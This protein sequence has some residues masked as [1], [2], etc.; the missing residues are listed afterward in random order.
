MLP[1][2]LPSQPARDGSRLP[3][4]TRSSDPGR[5]GACCR[6][7]PRQVQGIVRAPSKNGSLALLTNSAGGETEGGPRR[8][9]IWRS[10]RGPSV[11]VVTR[12]ADGGYR[13]RPVDEDRHAVAH[14]S[15]GRPTT[16][17]NPRCSGTVPMPEWTPASIPPIG[18]RVIEWRPPVMRWA[19]LGCTRADSCWRITL[20]DATDAKPPGWYGSIF[21][22]ELDGGRAEGAPTAR[23]PS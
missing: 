9:S 21:E 23:S 19:G 18:Q 4:G 5:F 3:P 15:L 22:G 11:R 2:L 17:S 8:V 14:K 1:R 16:G 12:N 7:I 20:V 6:G 13:V 10:F